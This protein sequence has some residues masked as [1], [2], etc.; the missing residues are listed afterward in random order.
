MVTSAS[1]W[2]PSSRP[3]SAIEKPRSACSPRCRSAMPISAR[4]RVGSSAAFPVDLARDAVVDRAVGRLAN[5][6]HVAAF[7]RERRGVDDRFVTEVELPHAPGFV[8]VEPVP[9][10]AEHRHPPALPFAEVVEH[11]ERVRERLRIADRVTRHEPDTA[12]VAVRDRGAPV[13]REHVVLVVAQRER[14]ERVTVGPVHEVAHP[15][16]R[17]RV[18]DRAF[19]DR[20]EHDEEQE[21]HA[22]DPDDR[23]RCREPLAEPAVHLQAR[24]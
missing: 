16:A 8:H 4:R 11:L 1:G 24:R 9:A 10:G 21:Q 7:E 15:L 17:Q 3:S 20:R 19:G 18:G 12:H 13:R 14:V 22:R 6:P 2:R 23:D 5:R